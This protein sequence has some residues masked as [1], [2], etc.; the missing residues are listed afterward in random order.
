M[1]DDWLQKVPVQNDDIVAA[2][3]CVEQTI[4]AV[5]GVIDDKACFG[6]SLGQKPGD[7]LIVF[8]KQDF[9]RHGRGKFPWLAPKEPC[10]ATSR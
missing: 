7:G 5:I 6:Q 8:D 2:V 4:A 1:A 9:L 10:L 3:G